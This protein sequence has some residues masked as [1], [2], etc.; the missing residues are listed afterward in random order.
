MSGRDPVFSSISSSDRSIVDRFRSPRKSI[1]S[2]PS[3]SMACI[4]NWVTISA[5]S[6]F[7]W[8]GTISVIGAG[9]MTTAAA[10]MESWRRSPSSPRAVSITRRESGSPACSSRSPAALA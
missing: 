9:E 4:S 5:P 3:S 2:R 1:F 6:P 8:M 10:W 7:C